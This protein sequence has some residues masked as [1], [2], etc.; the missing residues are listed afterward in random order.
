MM[1]EREAALPQRHSA[2]MTTSISI[3][4]GRGRKGRGEGV[5]R[6]LPMGK[7]EW[8]ARR[9]AEEGAGEGK[10]KEMKKR[11]ERRREPVG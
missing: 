2:M 9:L 6:N 10:S 1:I 11:E 4:E 5:R 8:K 7:E 3:Q